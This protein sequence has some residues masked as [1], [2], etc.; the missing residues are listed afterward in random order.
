MF[1]RLPNTASANEQA[2][3]LLDY[4]NSD[5]YFNS[6]EQ[7]ILSE[8]IGFGNPDSKLTQ[9][10]QFLIWKRWMKHEELFVDRDEFCT[11]MLLYSTYEQAQQ[12]LDSRVHPDPATP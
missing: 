10:E 1:Q 8:S 12:D 11:S 9:H 7:S 2:K 5:E 4:M 3:S 6:M